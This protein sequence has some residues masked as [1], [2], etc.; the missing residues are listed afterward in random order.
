MIKQS[1]VTTPFYKDWFGQEQMKRGG[2]APNKDFLKD[3]SI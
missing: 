3:D 1:K 2:T